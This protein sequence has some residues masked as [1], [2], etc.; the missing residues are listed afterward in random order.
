MGCDMV[1]VLDNKCPACGAKIEF[2]P[3]NQMWDCEYCYSKF[4]LEEMKAYK[5]A[6]ND[7]ANNIPVL[8]VKEE[9][10]IKEDNL[11]TEELNNAIHSC[12]VNAISISEEEKCNCDHCE[13]ED[14]HC[15]EN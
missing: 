4:T 5:N 3:L 10:N 13:C 8:E 14:C 6:S 12:P 15:E 1:E 2:N 7:T 9:K 11:E